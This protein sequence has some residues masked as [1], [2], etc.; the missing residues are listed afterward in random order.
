[1]G[2]DSETSFW[3][4]QLVALSLNSTERKKCNYLIPLKLAIILKNQKKKFNSRDELLDDLYSLKFF[5][6]D[7]CVEARLGVELRTLMLEQLI[8]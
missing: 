5:F 2:K 8:Q 3:S 1:M 6:Q 4:S 7:N